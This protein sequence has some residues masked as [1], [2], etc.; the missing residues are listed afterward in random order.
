MGNQAIRQIELRIMELKNKLE[1]LPENAPTRRLTQL[2][3]NDNIKLL[4]KLDP[5]SPI[6]TK[7][8]YVDQ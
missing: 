7:G 1:M 6:F 5:N 8:S 3:L 2:T 4:A